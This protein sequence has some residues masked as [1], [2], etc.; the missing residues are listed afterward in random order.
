MNKLPLLF[1]FYL[2]DLNICIEYDGE[3][4]FTINEFFGGEKNFNIRVI[5]DNIKT[6]FCNKN[7]IKLIRIPYYNFNDI[8][9]I[10]AKEL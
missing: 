9:N 6:E 4:H 7:K 10:L 2:I 1:D 3:Q 8:E 5:N